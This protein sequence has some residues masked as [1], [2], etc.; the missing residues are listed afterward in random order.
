MR[1]PMQNCNDV[2]VANRIVKTTNVTGMPFPI[3]VG[4]IIRLAIATV[5]GQVDMMRDHNR[6]AT[7]THMFFEIIHQELKAIHRRI[8]P[9]L[10]HFRDL[11]NNDSQVDKMNWPP[12]P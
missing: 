9:P 4:R 7:V 2:V 1:V 12:V 6:A 5:T 3:Q 8:T 11:P 10:R